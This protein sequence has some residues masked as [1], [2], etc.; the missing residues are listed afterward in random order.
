MSGI[1]PATPE[2]VDGIGMTCEQVRRIARDGAPVALHQGGL[3]RARR[4]REVIGR[5]VGSRLVYGRTTGV[6]ANRAVPATEKATGDTGCA[7]IRSHL[8]CG[9]AGPV[10][11]VGGRARAMLA[12]RLNQLAAGGAGVDPAL[13]D[14]LAQ[15]LNLGLTPPVRMVGAIG[16]GDLTALASTALCILGERPWQ[17]GTLPPFPL[18]PADAGAFMSSNAATIGEAALACADLGEL[19]EAAVVVAAMSFLAVNGSA[20]SYSPAVHAARPHPGQQAVAAR[21]RALLAGQE[22]RPDRIQDPYG[23]RALPQVHGPAVDAVGALDRV[24][25]VELNAAAEN[26]MVDVAAGDIANNGN[27]YTAYLGLGLDAARAALF[28]TAAR[29]AARLRTLVEARRLPSC[30]RSWPT[31]SPPARSVMA[32]EYVAHSA[33]ADIRGL[34]SPAALGSAVLSRGLEEQA[35]FSTQAARAATD[36][37]AAYRIVLGCE[38]VAAVRAL[39]MRGRER[40]RRGRCGPVTTWP[41]GPWIRGRRTGR[42]TR[43]WT[44]PIG[45]CPGWPPSEPR[46]RAGGAATPARR[47][48]PIRAACPASTRVVVDAAVQ[49]AELGEPGGHGRDRELASGSTSSTSSQL[50]GVDTVASGTPRTE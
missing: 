38:L 23:Y 28:Q 1:S 17:G 2:L 49:V 12:V 43:T 31:A 42:W 48:R 37:V 35:N 15:A 32:L 3:E 21:M 24:L 16:T 6:G 14:V 18:D 41:R 47:G 34:A 40:R 19:L 10:L 36:T 20:E 29:S 27:F 50:I 45:C 26:P 46:S 33:L 11:D 30:C 13:L 44:W 9:G 39:G 25:S 22:V 4:A 8:A 7:L 5:V